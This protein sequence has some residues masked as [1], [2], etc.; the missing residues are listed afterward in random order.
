MKVRIEIEY[1]SECPFSQLRPTMDI[2]CTKLNKVL[3]K[4]LS[5]LEIKIEDGIECKDL[6][7]EECPFNK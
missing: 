5:R 2:F 7:P 3:Y 6:I 1:C 4:G